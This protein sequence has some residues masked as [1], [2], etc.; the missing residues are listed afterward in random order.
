MMN[1]EQ[2]KAVH[3]LG[4]SFRLV[5]ATA[6]IT[7]LC[8]TLNLDMT[9]AGRTRTP[10]RFAKFLTEFFDAKPPELTTFPFHGSPHGS[11][12][13]VVE[14]NIRFYTLC[15]HHLLP[16]FGTAA[17][18]YIPQESVIGIS[19]LARIVEY[20][21][22]DIQMQERMTEEIVKML[23]E[24]VAPNYGVAVLLRARHLCQEMRGIRA[25]EAWTTTSVYTGKFTTD[26]HLKVE[27]LSHIS[28]DG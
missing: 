11:P 9:Q 12:Q 27:F 13:M 4:E 14:S 21:S 25:K 2:H 3:T 8:I 18:A 24:A 16:F 19:K 7:D 10:E 22:R 1:D 15:E 28:R 26:D 23:N 6:N 17:V 5:S 20:V